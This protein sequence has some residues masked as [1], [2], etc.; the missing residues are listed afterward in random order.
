MRLGCR[1]L[2]I[3][4]VL[5]GSVVPCAQAATVRQSVEGEPSFPNRQLNISALP[6]ERNALALSAG[7]GAGE[8]VVRDDGA[9][10]TAEAECRARSDGSV[11]CPGKRDVDGMSRSIAVN[12]GDEDDVAIV[13]PGVGPVGMDGGAGADRL[14]GGGGGDHLDGGAGPDILAGGDGDD[15]FFDSPYGAASDD[16]MDGGSGL[17]TASY[18]LHTLPIAVSMTGG[19]VRSAEQHDRF[20][21]LEGVEGGDGDDRLIGGRGRDF[22]AGGRGA[23]RIVGGAGDDALFG[24]DGRDAIDG[25]SGDDLVDGSLPDDDRIRCGVGDDVQRPASGRRAQPGCERVSVTGDVVV[26]ASQA[27]TI[28]ARP[29]RVHDR[30]VTF[31]VRCPRGTESC[32]AKLTVRDSHGRRLG[33]SRMTRIRAGRRASVSIRCKPSP[34]G[35]TLRV[36]ADL[37]RGEPLDPVLHY[38]TRR[39]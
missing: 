17:D 21:R 9:E 5:L 2:V 36:D 39:R 23:D 31:V 27:I 34:P 1:T 32:S 20:K 37:Q 33:R 35:G 11:S 13:G 26:H 12:L 25:G 6:G 3:T 7:T 29:I 38:L 16:L 18:G 10:L 30:S 28:G 19:T 24:D 4:A 14:T 15:E 22:F 8:I